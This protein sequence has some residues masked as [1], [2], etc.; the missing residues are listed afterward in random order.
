MPKAEI[1]KRPIE[2]ISADIKKSAWSAAIESLLILIFGIL[3]VVWPD[4]TIIAIANILGTIFIISGIYQIINYFVVKGQNDFFNNGLLIG[5][6]AL[7][8]GI[9]I[10][11][12][13]TDLAGVFRVIIGIWMVYEALVR[14]NTAIKLHSV[15]IKAWS[16]VL[17]IAV[18][19]LAV[20]IF[21]TFN[22]GAVIQLIG[23]M[24][25]LSGIFGILGDI[26]FIQHVNTVTDILTGKTSKEK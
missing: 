20:G 8:L 9:T 16:Y 7:L 6:L 14:I 12:I 17:I 18:C 2:R 25:I 19:M 23:W 10:L 22:E 24:M 11:L 13:G 1:I 21:V 15:G 26:L 3:M 5:V 4:I